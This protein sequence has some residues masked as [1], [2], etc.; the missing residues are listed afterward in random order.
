MDRIAQMDN[1]WRGITIVRQQ[2]ECV[3]ASALP[4]IATPAL[5]VLTFSKS[6]VSIYNNSKKEWSI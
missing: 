6:I 1:P 2:L 4:P 3:K 5:L